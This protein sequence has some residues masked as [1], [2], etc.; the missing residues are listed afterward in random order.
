MLSLL[1]GTSDLGLQI[2]SFQ[3]FM[4]VAFGVKSMLQVLDKVSMPKLGYLLLRDRLGLK[5]QWLGFGGCDGS[6]A[7]I[8]SGTTF[9]H[10]VLE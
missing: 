1:D 3:R 6:L 10:L 8:V 5:K 2:S 9:F 7:S 4:L